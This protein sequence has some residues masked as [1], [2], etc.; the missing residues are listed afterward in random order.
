MLNGLLRNHAIGCKETN[1]DRQIKPGTVLS[2]IGGC[3]I[4]RHPLLPQLDAGVADCTVRTRSLDS[5]TDVSGSSTSSDPGNPR[6]HIHLNVYN[7]SIH[8]E[9]RRTIGLC[10]QRSFP[11]TLIVI[12]PKILYPSP[13]KSEP[14]IDLIVLYWIISI[15]IHKYPHTT[16]LIRPRLGNI[17]KN[18]R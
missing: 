15:R 17:H 5:F 8:P 11:P 18:N 3:K 16:I 7:P 14:A 10:K 2:H 4:H 1:G 9:G 6:R 12:V 13:R